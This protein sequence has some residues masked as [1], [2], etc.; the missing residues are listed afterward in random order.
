LTN[1]A[2]T[3]YAVRD[4]ER[5]VRVTVRG[6]LADE[7]ET[8]LIGERFTITAALLPADG[9]DQHPG[10]WPERTDWERRRA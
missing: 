7:E 9:I 8:R 3:A 1:T 4:Y 5:A 10:R 6:G 2:D